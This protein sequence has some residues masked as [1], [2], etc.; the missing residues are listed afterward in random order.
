MFAEKP[1]A[2]QRLLETFHRLSPQKQQNILDFSEFLLAQ[3][4]LAADTE[5]A[6]AA[7]TLEEENHQRL[8][9]HVHE[10]IREAKT[11][12]PPVSNRDH[13]KHLYGQA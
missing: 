5:T 12:G 7:E 8:M 4:N 11:D 3:E 2:E 6:E 10:I 13:D 9:T 1:I